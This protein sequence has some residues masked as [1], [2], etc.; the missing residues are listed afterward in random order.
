M[1]IILAYLFYFVFATWSPLQR[2]VLAKKT[3]YNP[4]LIAQKTNLVKI[5]I[6]TIVFAL[7]P[8]KGSFVFS[9]Q[10]WILLILSCLFSVI[11]FVL[12]YATQKH[13]DATKT[14]IIV[15]VYTPVS[16]L[17]AT[18]FLGE[19]LTLKQIFGTLLL[20]LAVVIIS[21]KKIDNKFLKIDKYVLRM[22]I[23]GISLGIVLVIERQ[24]MII[25][26]N[27]NGVFLSWF[28]GFVGLSIVAPLVSKYFAGTR[29]SNKDVIVTAGLNFLQQA[30]WPILVVAV[31]SF[32]VVS[33]VTTFKIVVV[34]VASYLFLHE[35]DHLKR[36]IA[37]SILALIGLLLMK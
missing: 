7:I 3:N 11:H 31:G 21:I 18:I 2:R 15:N 1:T 24:L 12:I 29:P 4:I 26:G 33:S 19:S 22:L 35:K 36:K 28:A 9:K 20:L 13:I 27:W 10:L 37:G 6:G 25:T 17:L 5:L 23:V 14:T 34:F 8:N 30:S 16:I 32:S